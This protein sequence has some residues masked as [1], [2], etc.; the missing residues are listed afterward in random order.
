MALIAVGGVGDDRA[1]VG[2][3]DENDRAGNRIEDRR[4]V[5]GIAAHAAQRVWSRDHV[6][7]LGEQ[8]FENRFPVGRRLS[9]CAMHQD[10]G[11]DL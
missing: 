2:M 4:Y 10:D 6:V 9:A 7:S 3:T 1:A 5:G 8:Q 11:D